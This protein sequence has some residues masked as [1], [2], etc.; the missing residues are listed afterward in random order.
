MFRKLRNR[1]IIIN[2]AITTVILA[3]AF[4]AIYVSYAAFENG[5]ANKWRDDPPSVRFFDSN[6]MRIILEERIE[7]SSASAN[8][9]LISLVLIGVATE[10]M[11]FFASFYFA[12]N[13]IQPIR[14]VYQKQKDFIADASHELKTP[15]A[16]ALANF[17]A[18]ETED[19]AKT[20]WSKNTKRELL[21]IQ[22]LATS[23]LNLAKT[24][25]NKPLVSVDISELVQNLIRQNQRR[26]KDKTVVSEIES[27][28]CTKTNPEDIKQLF[29]ILLDNAIKYSKHHIGIR[30]AK[31]SFT[32]EN[33]GGTI[34]VEELPKI[35]DRF[36]R[37]DKS[38]HS[39]GFGLGLSIAKNIV[40]KHRWQILVAS[41]NDRTKFT[42]TFG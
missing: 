34:P 18:M 5:H 33:D 6:D 24:E 25:D 31:N 39:N 37:A 14:K 21:K 27:K 11:V 3:V 32:I 16:A 13:S 26:L 35:F 41:A 9:L 38:R 1:F 15:I 17:E 42:V 23:L 20:K 4:S 2:M 10:I 30:L 8:R 7:E 22:A 19:G 29:T 36:Y 12:E 28:V 40:E